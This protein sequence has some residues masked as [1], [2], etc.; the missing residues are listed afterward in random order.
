MQDC[1]DGAMIESDRPRDVF[2]ARSSVMVDVYEKRSYTQV[3]IR[4][5]HKPR[6][7]VVDY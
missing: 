7:V 5:G 6:I 3:P 2:Y 1:S 4:F